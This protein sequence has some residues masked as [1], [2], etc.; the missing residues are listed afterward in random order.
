LLSLPLAFHTEL[1]SIPADVPYL[2][3][4]PV[5]V[6]AWS[7]RLQG[8]GL[9]IGI[10]WAGNPKHSRDRQRSI[11]LAQLE[12]LT[13]VKGTTFY[14]LQK[15]DAAAQIRDLPATMKVHD[16]DAAVKDFADTAALVA[17][18][19]L[20]ISVDTAPAH[21]AGAMGKPVWILLHCMP[22]WRWLLERE[23][24]LWYPT[25]RL[26]RQTTPDNWKPVIERLRLELERMTR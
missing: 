22:D 5:E 19:D 6:E 24:S 17:N 9:R 13:Q 14:S 7:R 12:P 15:G 23:D 1:T 8:D 4:D 3:P 21:L 20:V 26:F 25:A 10:T 2:R 18:L 16:L 11:A